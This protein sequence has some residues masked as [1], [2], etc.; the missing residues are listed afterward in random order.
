MAK[1]KLFQV[2]IQF[3]QKK[4]LVQKL[5]SQSFFALKNF[6]EKFFVKKK[7]VQKE[8]LIQK[9]LEEVIDRSIPANN[10][11]VFLTSPYLR[12]KKG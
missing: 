1:K 11:R 10:S 7:S 2:Q 12:I 9:N 6:Q 4:F 3:G 5:F 8:F